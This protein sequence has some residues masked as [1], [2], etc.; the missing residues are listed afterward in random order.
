M[1]SLS[2]LTSAARRAGALALTGSLAA[3][4]FDVS[5]VTTVP[6]AFTARD[7]CASPWRLTEAVEIGLGTG[8]PTRLRANT[9][10]RCI[11]ETPDGLVF[12]TDDQVV[13]VEASNIYEARVVLR[14]RVLVGFYLPVERR[15]APV[16]PP[17]ALPVQEDVR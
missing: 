15:L 11:G 17:R 2:A 10:W 6:S 5:H 9:R 13:T 12:Q 16:R 1:L 8:F 3:C 7:E 14:D 4:A